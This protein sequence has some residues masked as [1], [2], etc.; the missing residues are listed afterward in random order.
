MQ[1]FAWNHLKREDQFG[2]YAVEGFHV[3]MSRADSNFKPAV[4]AIASGFPIKVM[5]R[6]P[7]SLLSSGKLLP[8]KIAPLEIELSMCNDLSDWLDTTG[9]STTDI[10]ISDVQ[11][12]FDQYTLDSAVEQSFYSALLKNKVLSVPVFNIYQVVHAIP[13]GATTF[14]FSSVRAF[15]RLAQ[16]WLHF[17][18]TGPRATE[19]VCPGQLPGNELND[20]DVAV[21]NPGNVPTARLSLGPK[22]FPDPQPISSAAEYYYNLTKCLGYQPN[23]NRS[24]FEKDCFCICWDLKKQPQDPTSALST[25]SGEMIRV[26]IANM[27]ANNATECW[28]TLISFGVVAIRE[29]GVTLLT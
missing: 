20:E 26:E 5:H 14:S 11:I 2:S 25:R 21:L 17:R 7:L 6:L 28:M 12:L 13:A 9:D 24:D 8:V 16:V 4:G 23:I 18:K 15:S 22:N 3:S 27:V 19:F 10:T 29:S 1:T